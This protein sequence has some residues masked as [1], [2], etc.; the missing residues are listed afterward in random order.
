MNSD[1]NTP[2]SPNDNDGK[3]KWLTRKE[4]T[5][6]AEKKRDFW[7]GVGIFF[8]LNIALIL[9]RWG[10]GY[11]V[12]AVSPDTVN[13][14]SP[15]AMILGGMILWGLLLLP[16]VLNIG[17]I[18]FFALTRSQVALGMVAGFGIALVIVICLGVIF[19]VWCF[20]MLGS[21]SY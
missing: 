3:P 8:V 10:L 17:L 16:W 4:Y 11:G 9:C 20:A 5:D 13:S 12:L 15:M 19:T 6:P 14:S 2:I 7:L 21:G 18:V 1:N